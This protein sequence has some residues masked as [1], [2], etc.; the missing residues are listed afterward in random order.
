MRIYPF[1]L[2]SMPTAS[3]TSSAVRIVFAASP[4]CAVLPGSLVCFLH[5]LCRQCVQLLAVVCSSAGHGHLIHCQLQQFILHQNTAASAAAHHRQCQNRRQCS[6]CQ[7]L[8][9]LHGFVPPLCSYQPTSILLLDP[10][11]SVHQH[12]KILFAI[13]LT[14][15][16]AVAVRIPTTVADLLTFTIYQL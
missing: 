3:T 14:H 5:Q 4:L 11:L 10:R 12:D 6:G 13:D 16:K 15:G 9:Q 7:F 8:E 2:V 1:A